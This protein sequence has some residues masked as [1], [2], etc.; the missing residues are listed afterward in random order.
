MSG[1]GNGMIK[2]L[3]RM[4]GP[5]ENAGPV[6]LRI[7]AWMM[8]NLPGQLTCVEFDRFVQDY[9]DG[10]LSPRQE[11]EFDFHMELCPMCRVY[12]ASYLQT[13]ELGK[14][15]CGAD[16]DASP[17]LP[18]ELVIAILAARDAR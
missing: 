8:R 10:V 6:G 12:F 3:S 1:Q 15:A 13:I 7:R 14:R 11:S 16:D 17:D 5:H 18:E 4:M 9:H 2:I